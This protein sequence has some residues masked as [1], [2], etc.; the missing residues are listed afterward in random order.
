ME[1]ARRE[2]ESGIGHWLQTIEF[3][4]KLAPYFA[5][6][7]AELSSSINDERTKVKDNQ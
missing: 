2:A 4:S 7:S 6:Q 5:N 1:S 3:P